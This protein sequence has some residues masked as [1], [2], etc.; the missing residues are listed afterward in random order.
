MN[1]VKFFLPFFLLS[2]FSESNI[3]VNDASSEMKAEAEYS[4]SLSDL[5]LRAPSVYAQNLMTTSYNKGYVAGKLERARLELHGNE[6]SLQ[7]HRVEVEGNDTKDIRIMSL[8][9]ES[10]KSGYD[11][12]YRHKL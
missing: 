9:I 2:C 10:F 12:G 7:L 11:N 5:L 4:Q 6:F 1:L 8:M 3:Y